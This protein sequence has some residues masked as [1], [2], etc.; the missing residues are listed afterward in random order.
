MVNNHP[1]FEKLIQS[2][3]YEDVWNRPN[4]EKPIYYE[5][6]WVAST[7]SYRLL[8]FKSPEYKNKEGIFQYVNGEGANAEAVVSDF[9]KCYLGEEKPIG[10]IMLSDIEEILNGIALL[11]E[12]KDKYKTCSECD[13]HGTVE[14][15]CCGH[16]N[17]CSEC[18][19]EGE[20][21]CGKEEDGSYRFPI[22]ECIKIN[23]T[24]YSLSKMRDLIDS[25]SLVDVKELNVYQDTKSYR[26]FFGIPDSEVFI[27]TMGLTDSNIMEKIHTIETKIL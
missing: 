23:N 9:E 5:S 10:K 24:I 18:D 14:C 19:G 20:V 25:L 11:P 15:D 1:N 17:D 16:E 4:I 26:G 21:K 22:D 8:W 12:Y 7:D 13:G 6:G 2:F 3:I 27:L